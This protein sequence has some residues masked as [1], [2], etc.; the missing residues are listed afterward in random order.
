MSDSTD[1]PSQPSSTENNP[2]KTKRCPADFIFGKQIGE[3]SFSVVYLA[4]DIHTHKE[5]AVKVCE[6]RQIIRERKQEYVKREREALNRMSGVPGFLKLFCTFQDPTKLFFVVTYAK[7]G[8]LLGLMESKQKLDLASVRFY[9]AQIVLAIEEMHAKNIIHRDL[10]PENILLDDEFHV[11]IADFGSSRIGDA[12]APQADPD[13]QTGRPRSGS[14]VGTAQYVSPEILRG[15]GSSEA[16]DLWSFACI[17]YQMIAGFPPFQGANDYLIFQKINNLELTFPENFNSDAED[18]V[19]KLL[20]QHPW[21]RL[22]M[23]DQTRYESIRK[24]H[25]FEDVNFS[26]IRS[27]SAPVSLEHSAAA[28]DRSF[29]TDV[30]PGLDAEQIARLLGQDWFGMGASA[31]SSSKLP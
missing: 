21:E 2:R 1:E 29:S 10:K 3:G 6:K 25:F 4:K 28:D 14:F 19:R 13:G 12:Q 20:V 8:T 11:M 31:G 30:K 23:N 15:R 26:T 16:S 27:T 5:W 7:N 18:L 24:H 22:G 17:L 9:A